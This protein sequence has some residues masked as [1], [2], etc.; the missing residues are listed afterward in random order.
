METSTRIIDYHLKDCMEGGFLK[1]KSIG[2]TLQ[3]CTRV[4]NGE[5][6]REVRAN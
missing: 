4:V 5:F 1:M 6:E 3:A 2:S